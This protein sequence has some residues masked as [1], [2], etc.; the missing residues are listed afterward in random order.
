MFRWYAHVRIWYRHRQPVTTRRPWLN[1]N[2]GI[3]LSQKPSYHK[4]NAHFFHQLINHSSWIRIHCCLKLSYP[5]FLPNHS[6]Q[7]R[8]HFSVFAHQ[9]MQHL[10]HRWWKSLTKTDLF[11]ITIIPLHILNCLRVIRCV[12]GWEL[13]V[14]RFRWRLVD[15]IEWERKL[16]EIL[17]HHVDVTCF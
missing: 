13:A 12:G 4:L 1:L 3:N 8:P 6:S 16:F 15:F 17:L 7:N 9:Q 10:N 11:R 14:I 2:R 5:I